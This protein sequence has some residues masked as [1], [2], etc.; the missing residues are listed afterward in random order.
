MTVSFGNFAS[1]CTTAGYRDAEVI[2]VAGPEVYRA[3]GPEGDGPV[4]VQFQLVVPPAIVWKSVGSLEE[5]RLDEVSFH[6]SRHQPS[7]AEE[8]SD[9]WRYICSSRLFEEKRGKE[10]RSGRSA[11]RSGH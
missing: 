3:A 8:A 5:H 6:A 4:A 1:P 10:E 7:L 2:V 11:L 9:T